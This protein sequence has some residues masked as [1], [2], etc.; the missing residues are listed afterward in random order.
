MPHATQ[1]RHFPFDARSV[2][3]FAAIA[4]GGTAAQAQTSS[5]T[6]AA[7]SRYQVGPGPSSPSQATFGGGSTQQTLDGAFDRA[8]ANQDDK[9][10][11]A[12]AAALPAIGNRFKALDRDQDGVLSRTEF[13]A[14]ARS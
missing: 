11:A 5:P 3:L 4:V 13:A 12:E 8:D 7:Q 6:T 1:R 10:S 9:L 14:G 2:M